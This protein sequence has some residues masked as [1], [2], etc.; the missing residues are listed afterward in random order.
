M[1]N[2]HFARIGNRRSIPLGLVPTLDVTVLAAALANGVATGWRL[3]TLFGMPERDDA[4][5]LIAIV[6]DDEHAWLG[7]ASAVVEQHYPAIGALCQP[8]ARFEREIAEQ[9][10]AVPVGHPSLVSLR[11][12]EPDHK[13]SGWA[14]PTLARAEDAFHRVHG[15]EV[16]E[17]AVGPVHAGIIE[18]GHFRFQ[19]HGED[20][21]LLEIMLGF[22]HRG[23]EPLLETLPRE[24]AIYVA[25][26]IA[27]DTV[28]AHAGAYCGAIEALA[29]SHKSPRAQSVRGIALELERLANH[30]GDLG[31]ISGDVA[32]QPA[33][34][35]FGRMRGECLNLLMTISGNR[36]GRGLIRPGGV[37]FDIPAD[38]AT[39]VGARLERLRD[40]LRPVAELFFGASSVQS[41][42]EGV[43]VVT[44]E[45]CVSHGFVGP[46]ARSCEVRRDARHDHPYGVFR[47]AQIPV[48]TAWA[49]DV[50]AR[51]LIRWV[52]VQRSLDFVIEQIASLPRGEL[53]SEC[54]P[55]V[56]GELVV[57]MEEGWRGEVAHVVLTDDVG[58]VRRHKVTDPSFHNWPAVA[59]ALPGNQISDFPLCNKSFNLSYA[60]HDL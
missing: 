41:R 49:G 50:Y 1:S 58:R 31:A 54:G 36:L 7:V 27:G 38:M 21:L 39:D 30:I 9:C 42:L 56:A 45:Q 55:L 23:V 43:G 14:T 44:S 47:F 40:E 37:A 52:E 60:G 8:A 18:P 3:V 15:D 2:G 10:G 53:R 20:V 35:Y 26:A 46:V 25:E 33:A 13:P 24:R 59:V 48:A 5:R 22:Q 12:H 51:A 4:L 34:A 11:R 29:R 17:V 57:A 19:A 28:I 16:H 32:Y 6:S